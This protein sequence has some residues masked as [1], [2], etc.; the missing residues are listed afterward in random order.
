[1]FFFISTRISAMRGLSTA[2]QAVCL[3]ADDHID[4]DG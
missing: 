3:G 2:L 1:M 4:G